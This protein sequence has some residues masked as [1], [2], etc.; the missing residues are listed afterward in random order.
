L[1][2]NDLSQK[3]TLAIGAL[4]TD[5]DYGSIIGLIQRIGADS[6][7][8]ITNLSLSP[9][10]G[11]KNIG[12]AVK[13]EAVGLK[14]SINLMIAS[15]EKSPRIMKLNSID[16]TASNA[17]GTVGASFVINALYAPAP[18]SLGSVDS[19]LPKLTSHDEEVLATL[20]SSSISLPSSASQLLPRGKSNPFQ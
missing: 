16:I 2:A 5:K 10:I 20:A 19:E 7:V 18:Q 4:P 15:I 1:D 6:G 14:Q 9:V 13:V 17:D 11:D 12:F 3:L 8:S